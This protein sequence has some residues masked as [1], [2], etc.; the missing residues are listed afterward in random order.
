ME[1]SLASDDHQQASLSS[2]FSHANSLVARLDSLDHRTDSFKSTLATAISLLT[3]CRQL[4][5]Q[6][7]LF[8]PN[9]SLEDISTASLPYLSI[10]YALCELS[11]KT[12]SR[13]RKAQLREAVGL[14][15][16]FL[17]RCEDYEIL[18]PEDRRLWGRVKEEGA[19]FRVVGAGVGAEGRRDVK[20]RR[21]REE[22]AI[23]EKL[24]VSLVGVFVAMLMGRCRFYTN[25]HSH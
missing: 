18:G 1:D 22:K 9:E 15:E 20:V 23:K 16:E 3:Q 2:L 12:Y 11:L 17:G 13:D 24:R 5:D 6:H 10:P 25:S 8:S 7:T 4:V 21:F 19:S 14:L